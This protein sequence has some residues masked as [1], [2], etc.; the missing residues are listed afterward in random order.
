MVSTY[1]A[2]KAEL[3]DYDHSKITHIF[4]HSLIVDNKIAFSSSNASNYNSV[5]TT[6]PEFKE[7]LQEMYDKGYVLVTMHDICTF[8][9]SGALHKNP[10]MLPPG[11]IPFVISQDDVCYYEY[12]EG[13]GFA[14][15]FVIGDDGRPTLEYK[16]KN[17]K[18]TTGDYDLVPILDHFVDEHPDFSYKGS[19]AILAFTGYNGI[20]GYRTDETYDP[21]SPAYN[22]EKYRNENI[23]NDKAMVK[24][25][26]QALKEDGYEFAS[27]SWGHIRTGDCTVERLKT[28][29]DKWERNV[30]PLLPDPCPIM[31]YPFGSDIGNWHPYADDNEKFHI[32]YDAG[33]RYY[34]TVDSA[35]YWLQYNSNYMRGGRRNVDGYRMYQ[36]LAGGQNKLGDIIDVKKVFDPDRPTPVEQ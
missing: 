19:K 4:F 6:I 17:G 5:M 32:L 35:Q 8:D 27:H 33:F 15:R 21:N 30:E 24:K 23:E 16:D 11:K 25:I 22:P 34:L 12:M 1:E 13:Q 7:I 18:V 14:T 3:K 10:I 29:T 9:E 36:D 26:T 2:D 28:D 31:I 20:L